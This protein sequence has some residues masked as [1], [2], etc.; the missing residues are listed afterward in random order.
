MMRD[1]TTNNYD[2][3]DFYSFDDDIEPDYPYT[4]SHPIRRFRISPQELDSL[5]Y[6]ENPSSYINDNPY[7]NY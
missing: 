2:D 5:P 7:L 1:F 6:D 3:L 4:P